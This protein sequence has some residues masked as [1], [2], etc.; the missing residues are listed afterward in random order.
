MFLKICFAACAALEIVFVPWFLIASKNGRCTKSQILKTICATLFVASGVLALIIA[1]NRTDYAKYI[2]IGLAL[3]WCGDF[4]LHLEYRLPV[5]AAGGLFF[6]AGHVYYVMA[7]CRAISVFFPQTKF[8]NRQELVACAAIIVVGLVA[9]RILGVKFSPI[10]FAGAPYIAMLAFML[11]KAASL[12][13]RCVAAGVENAPIICA[14]LISGAFL[15]VVSDMMLAVNSLRK[16][17]PPY[18]YKIICIV[19]YFSAQLLLAST[20]FV[21]FA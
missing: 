5:F 3:C 15:F 16:P 9:L 21:I 14:L 2:I 13:I 6:L 20:I 17:R 10:Y 11:T 18:I 8:W 12:G 1:G 7:Y 4:L 19:T